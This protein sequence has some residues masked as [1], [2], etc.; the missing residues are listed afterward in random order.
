MIKSLDDAHR[1]LKINYLFLAALS[2]PCCS[3]AYLWLW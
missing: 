2:L 1:Q 3:Q